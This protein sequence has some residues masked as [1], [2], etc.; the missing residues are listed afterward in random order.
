MSDVGVERRTVRVNGVDLA[1][2]HA[3]PDDAPLVVCLHG[4]PD[5]PVTWRHLLPR[6]VGAGYRVAA[7]WLRGYPPSQVVDGPYQIAA[8]AHDLVALV[9]ALSPDEPA[10]V[11]GHD[12]GGLATYGA[13]VLAP[14]RLRRAVVLSV[15]PSRSFRA[16]LRRDWDQQRAAWYQFF[17]QLEPLAETAVSAD[18][19]AFVERLWRAW[20]PD[21]EPDRDALDA[22]ITTV[23]DGFPA[24]LLFY[25]DTY[26]LERRDPALA[27]DQQRILDGPVPGPVLVLRGA[28][29][30]CILAGAYAEAGDYFAD[31]HAM[32]TV[33]GA[34]HFLHLERPD[35]VGDR[36]T[37]F[38]DAAPAPVHATDDD[39]VRRDAAHDGA[40][41]WSR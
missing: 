33:A 20:S 34:G 36:I 18:D 13:A 19:F 24:S 21:W 11:V 40:R 26:Q 15:P 10:H 2:L 41:G 7:P 23:R 12:W 29:D 37:A 4:F 3:G 32:E 28:R 27:G 8:V 22:A 30:G 17:F 9:D 31:G 14:D 39:T 6:L 5:S 38:L 1:Y 25:R 35:V 16:F